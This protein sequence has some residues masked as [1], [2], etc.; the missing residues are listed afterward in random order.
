[1]TASSPPSRHPEILHVEADIPAD[2]RSDFELAMADIL[3]GQRSRLET[4]EHDLERIKTR[5]LAGLE[6]IERSIEANP[7][8]GQSTYLVRFLAVA[9]QTMEA[10]LA[11]VTPS[12]DDAARSLGQSPAGALARVHAP[13]LAP[14]VATACLLLFVD[15]IKELPATFA[16]RT[17]DFDTLAVEA[18]NLAKDE[19]LAEAALPSLAIVAV[20]L[21]PLVVVLRRYF[22]PTRS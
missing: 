15:V 10:G 17:F 3:V 2:Q 20:A 9:L 8:A 11:R 4:L 12:M 13:L 1:M 6:F 21:M 16:M 5:A 19:R 7:T 14:S 18:Y 22:Q